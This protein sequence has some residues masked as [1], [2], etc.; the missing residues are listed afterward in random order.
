M[1]LLLGLTVV[2]A[3]KLASKV[4]KGR[5]LCNVKISCPFPLSD[6]IFNNSPNKYSNIPESISSIATVTDGLL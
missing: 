2:N 1:Y 4:S 3:T 5:R 6:I